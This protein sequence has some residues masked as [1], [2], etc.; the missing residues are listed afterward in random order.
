[1]EEKKKLTTE[2]GAPIGDNQNIQTAG[3]HGPALMQKCSSN[4]RYSR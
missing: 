4:V 2:A 1:M 3:P